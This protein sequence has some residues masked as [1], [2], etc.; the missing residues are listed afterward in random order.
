LDKVVVYRIDAQH[1]KLDDVIAGNE[2]DS[3]GETSRMGYRRMKK[4]DL[5]P[6]YPWDRQTAS[7]SGH[8]KAYAR[9]HGTSTGSKL[10]V[11]RN[12]SREV[13]GVL[14]RKWR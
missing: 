12:R 14:L 5:G 2:R 9:N 4:H 10:R 11:F 7:V 6:V 8:A 1:G 3:R 13:M